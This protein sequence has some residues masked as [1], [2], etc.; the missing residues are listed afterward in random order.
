MKNIKVTFWQLIDSKLS[1]NNC[2]INCAIK[3]GVKYQ[4]KEENK[5]ESVMYMGRIKGTI[6][7]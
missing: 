6:I 5:W 1:L 4:R 2:P 7:K 3:E